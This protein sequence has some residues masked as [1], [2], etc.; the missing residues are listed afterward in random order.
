MHYGPSE[1]TYIYGLS[2][3]ETSLAQW[4]CIWASE[5]K[6]IGSTPTRRMGFELSVLYLNSLVKHYSRPYHDFGSHLDE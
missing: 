6:V 3:H 5:K 4:W 1:K 2:S